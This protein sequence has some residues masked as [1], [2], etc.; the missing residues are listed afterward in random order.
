MSTRPTGN[1]WLTR[2]LGRTLI[3]KLLLGELLVNYS[4]CVLV[5]LN[6]YQHDNHSIGI[7]FLMNW[8]KRLDHNLFITKCHF[9]LA[10]SCA[11]TINQCWKM[12]LKNACSKNVL[13]LGGR[14]SYFCLFSF[15]SSFA[16]AALWWCWRWGVPVPAKEI[17]CKHEMATRPSQV[18]QQT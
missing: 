14:L 13:L 4:F 16:F 7:A 9:S 10:F 11:P 6:I 5:N 8:Q 15:V 1:T 3:L 17:P 2:S 12:H 18:L